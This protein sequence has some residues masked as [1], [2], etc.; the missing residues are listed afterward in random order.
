MSK[1]FDHAYI[2]STILLTVYSQV[3]MRWQMSMLAI[4]PDG[5]V[6]KLVFFISNLWRPWILTA[7]AATFLAGITWMIVLSKFK[8][9]YAFPFMALN[10]LLVMLAS[11]VFFGESLTSGKLIGNVL[12]IAGVVAL[13]RSQG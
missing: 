9:S 10:F 12:I 11:A 1:L 4:A 8:L 2:A 5:L 7:L 3:I 13:A 6:P